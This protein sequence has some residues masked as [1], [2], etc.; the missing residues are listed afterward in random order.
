[1]FHFPCASIEIQN[2]ILKF[3]SFII[4]LMLAHFGDSEK[5]YLKKKT[6]NFLFH[7]NKCKKYF[8]LE[9]VQQFEFYAESLF[10]FPTLEEISLLRHRE[11]FCPSTQHK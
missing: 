1:M 9:Q 3:F 8:A 5:V 6:Q 4:F 10:L 11:S 7:N 2:L